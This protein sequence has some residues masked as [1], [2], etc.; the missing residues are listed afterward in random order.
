[1]SLEAVAAGAAIGA[2]RLFQKNSN[3]LWAISYISVTSSIFRDTVFCQPTSQPLF[4]YQV[5]QSCVMMIDMTITFVLNVLGPA[6]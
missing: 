1:M 3:S 5:K 4:R 6:I 2:G